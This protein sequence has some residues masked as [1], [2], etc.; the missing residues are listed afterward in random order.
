MRR[1]LISVFQLFQ[2]F[3]LAFAH[4]GGTG[5]DKKHGGKLPKHGHGSK[6]K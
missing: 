6:K 1:F 5:S 3:Q 4:S 2:G